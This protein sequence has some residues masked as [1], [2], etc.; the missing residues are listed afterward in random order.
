VSAA[1]A[2]KFWPDANAIGKHV[3]VVWE[4]DWRTVVGVVG[5]VRQY[6]LSGKSPDYIS[7]DFYMPYSQSVGLDR[8]LPTAMTL[9]LRTAGNAPQIAGELRRLV[10]SVN[11]DVPVS[12]VRAMEAVV[13]TST[14]DS[15]SLMWLFISF[16]GA[17][18]VLAAIGAYGVVSYS[19]TQRTYEMGVRMALG[20]TRGNIFGLVLGQSLKLVLTGLALGVVASLLLTRLIGNFLYGVTATD[21]LTFLAV[22]VLLIVTGLLAGYFP[23]RRAMRVDPMVA[24]RYE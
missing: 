2:R 1:T 21:P 8:R 18:L 11:P 16:G 24:L 17:A 19:T 23:A 5:E 9:I 15:R 20:A 14:S 10:T 22:S 12:E 6:E 13:E 3:R 7:G 4:Q